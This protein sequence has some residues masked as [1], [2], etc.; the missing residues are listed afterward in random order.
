MNYYFIQMQLLGSSLECGEDV[1][2]VKVKVKVA[3]SCPTLGDPVDCSPPSFS[4]HG[5]LQARILEWAAIPFSG[6]YSQPRD[7][8]QVS[9]TAD[10]VFTV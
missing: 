1:T 5:I 9:D 7:R 4:V 3:Q 2:H 6:G 10:G 8:T